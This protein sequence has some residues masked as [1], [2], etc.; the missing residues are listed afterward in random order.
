LKGREVKDVNQ[1]ANLTILSESDNMSKGKKQL[2]E[3]LN[4]MTPVQFAA[5]CSRH[6]IPSDVRLYAR[7]NF[8]EFISERKKLISLHTILGKHLQSDGSEQDDE[9]DDVAGVDD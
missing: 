7:E 9:G 5:F 1:L 8:D 3:W 4:D 2:C 6:A